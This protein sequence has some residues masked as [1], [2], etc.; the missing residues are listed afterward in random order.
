MLNYLAALSLVSLHFL[1]YTLIAYLSRELMFKQQS[2]R[3]DKRGNNLAEIQLQS[4]F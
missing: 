1:V 2:E 4:P 3:T